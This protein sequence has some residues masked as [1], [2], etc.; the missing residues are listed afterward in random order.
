L[1]KEKNVTLEIYPLKNYRACGLI[2]NLADN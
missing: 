1:A 2:K